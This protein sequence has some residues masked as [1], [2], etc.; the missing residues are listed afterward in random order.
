[1]E[2]FSR[3][4]KKKNEEKELREWRRMKIEAKTSKWTQLL[5]AHLGD[6]PLP[7]SPQRVL[8]KE[9]VF[10]CLA[11]LKNFTLL[12]AISQLTF[13]PSRPSLNEGSS[14]PPKETI[15]IVFYLIVSSMEGE[16]YLY[17]KHFVHTIVIL[18]VVVNAEGLWVRNPFSIQSEWKILWHRPWRR[19]STHLKLLKKRFPCRKLKDYTQDCLLSYQ[20]HTR[21][22]DRSWLMTS[23]PKVAEG[24]GCMT[25]SWEVGQRIGTGREAG[26]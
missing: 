4:K 25:D 23:D 8:G 16:R 9:S 15:I 1:M 2:I 12:C 21:C 17:I 13:L 5:S 24:H 14:V 6:M 18:K 10:L 26:V 3:L 11:P 19:H 7:D 20:K 22:S